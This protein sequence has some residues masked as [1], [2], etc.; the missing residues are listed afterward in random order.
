MRKVIGIIIIC[1]ITAPLTYI[2][3]QSNLTVEILNLESNKGVAIVDL[4]DKDEESVMDLTSEIADNKCTLI[5]KDLKNG[6]YAIRYFHDENKNE[7]LDTNFIG[8]PKEGFG[9]S[10]DAIGKFGPKDFSEWLFEVSG[11]TLIKMTTKYMF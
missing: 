3:A 10:N 9:F 5:F 4:M 11:D 8:I 1:L 7:E 2:N 6:Q